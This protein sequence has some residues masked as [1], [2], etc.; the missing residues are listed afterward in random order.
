MIATKSRFSASDDPNGHG[1][2]RRHLSAAL[3]AS[4]RLLD[5][6][7][8]LGAPDYLYGERGQ[9]QRDRRISGGRL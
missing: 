4:L 2:S 8:D 5:A 9:S 6:A 7:S 1:L 3:D